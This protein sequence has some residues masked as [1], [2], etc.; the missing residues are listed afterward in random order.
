MGFFERLK[1]AVAEFFAV[2]LTG[3]AI[4]EIAEIIHNLSDTEKA[5]L[6]SIERTRW[7]ADSERAATLP[8]LGDRGLV[9]RSLALT[10]LGEQ[11]ARVLENVE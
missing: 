2:L 8:A 11:V 4:A 3:K 9:V 5:A 10:G 7:V 1:G 6:L